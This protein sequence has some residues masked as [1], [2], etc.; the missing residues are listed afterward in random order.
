VIQAKLQ[1][2]YGSVDK[3]DVFVGGLA[4]DHL[5]GAMVG[6]LYQAILVEQFE[7]LRAGDRFW[8]ENRFSGE[9]LDQI[10]SVT[11]AE[12]IQLNSDVDVLQHNAMLAY[13]RVGGTAANDRLHGS[14]ERDLLLGFDGHDRINAGRS[15]DHV[16]AGEGH[17]KVNGGAGDDYI[18][19]AGGNDRLYGGPGDDEL[20]GG[21][22]R[23][24]I[25]GGADSDHINGAGGND[26]LY[27]GRGDD[28]LLGGDGHDK[29]M[30][31][32]VTISSSVAPERTTSSAVL[33]RILFVSSTR[34]ISATSSMTSTHLL[35]S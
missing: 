25:M 15:D 17:D 9:D 26:R 3:I 27:G 23:D 35:T 14:E 19:G 30:A 18:N 21:D 16:E 5:D 10:G 6:P 13:D 32:G 4:E 22:G 29:I 12:I 31:A 8:Y 1:A 34:L 33:E 11:L 24:K 20:L 28:D 2:A 7:R